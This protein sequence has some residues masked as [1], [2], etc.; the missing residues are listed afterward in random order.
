[1]SIEKELKAIHQQKH[2]TEENW[3]KATSFKP[4]AGQ[5]IVYDADNNHSTPRIKIGDGSTNVNDLPFMGVD[6]SNLQVKFAD[7]NKDTN[8]VSLIPSGMGTKDYNITLLGSASGSFTS[9]IVNTFNDNGDNSYT[10]LIDDGGF[11]FNYTGLNG[12]LELVEGTEFT[13][14]EPANSSGPAMLSIPAEAT[15]V[16][17]KNVNRP[18]D[19]N[20]AANKIYV[21]LASNN[22]QDKFADV[23]TYQ[24]DGVTK[25]NLTTKGDISIIG[26]NDG[27][28]TS[29]DQNAYT[30][31]ISII[32]NIFDTPSYTHGVRIGVDDVR[33]NG[34]GDASYIFSKLGLFSNTGSPASRLEIIGND[35][36]RLT[37]MYRG[38]YMGYNILNEGSYFYYDENYASVRVDLATDKIGL[39]SKEVKVG[40]INQ[41][42]TITN[43]ATPVN[44]TD[45]VNKQY[46]DGA[47]D[48][49][50]LKDSATGE[51]YK[52]SITNGKLEME[53]V[54]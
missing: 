23:V 17:I 5:L 45:A 16:R 54:E 50:L 28:N 24:S 37:S 1:M 44:P 27:G 42:G 20:D 32:S 10:I 15:S 14:S 47:K 43:L 21:D 51:T 40:T 48:S 8:T 13:L 35:E 18:V 3:L 36:A 25:Y 52:L 26:A 29:L 38:L 34:D 9:G 46:V 49:I 53:V 33:P 12:A 6:T 41:A 22:K 39:N 31:K 7:V 30:G 11:A 4:R 19:D 2:D